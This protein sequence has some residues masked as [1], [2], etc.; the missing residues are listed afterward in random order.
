MIMTLG[1]LHQYL[2]KNIEFEKEVHGC[3]PVDDAKKED[4][5]QIV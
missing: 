1:W 5:E 2:I 3:G 4:G